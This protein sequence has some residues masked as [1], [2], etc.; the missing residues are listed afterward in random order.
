VADGIDN[1]KGT[2]LD[3]GPTIQAFVNFFTGKQGDDTSLSDR[4]RPTYNE[5]FLGQICSAV[6]N[7]LTLLRRIFT[8]DW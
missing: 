1:I 2:V 8:G 4:L 7:M 6:T 5:G 3:A